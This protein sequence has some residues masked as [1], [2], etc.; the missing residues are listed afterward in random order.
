MRKLKELLSTLSAT[1][2]SYIEKVFDTEEGTVVVDENLF[3]SFTTAYHHDSRVVAIVC[4]HKLYILR[5]DFC[6]TLKHGSLLLLRTLNM[7]DSSP[8]W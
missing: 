3:V 6:R 1:G 8:A 4:Y 2:G 7:Q 5:T